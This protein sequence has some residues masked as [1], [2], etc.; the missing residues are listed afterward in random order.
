MGHHLTSRY[1]KIN[2]P[3]Q[4][5]FIYHGT[6]WDFTNPLWWSRIYEYTWM[7]AAIREWG[8]ECNKPINASSVLD[9]ACG[10]MH[11]SPFILKHI[12]FKSVVC[13]D[14]LDTWPLAYIDPTIQYLKNDVCTDKLPQSDV[15][16]CVSTLEHIDP[17]KQEAALQNMISALNPGGLLLLTFDMPGWDFLT[18]LPLYKQVIVRNSM[19]I[20]IE[21]VPEEQR[22]N[23]RNGAVINWEL[24]NPALYPKLA[25][26]EYNIYRIAAVK[27]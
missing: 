18:N 4:L 10:H 21:E 22:L 25:G 9:I 14:L 1:I 5:G 13:T 23:S 17:A 19:H 16:I 15:I 24:S 20:L 2:D 11:P 3:Y 8:L 6:N 26:V 7:D 12:G 27:Q